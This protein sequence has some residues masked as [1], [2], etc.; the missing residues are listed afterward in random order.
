[1]SSR[2]PKLNKNKNHREQ[3]QSLRINWIAVFV[4]GMLLFVWLLIFGACSKLAEGQTTGRTAP[5]PAFPG[6][7]QQ[8]TPHSL[9][10]EQSLINGPGASTGHGELPLTEVYKPAPEIPLGTLARIC[11]DEPKDSH[12]IYRNK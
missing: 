5:P 9:A 2:G 1:M 3:P 10:P 8:A 6:T 11:R 7:P 12:C 4:Y